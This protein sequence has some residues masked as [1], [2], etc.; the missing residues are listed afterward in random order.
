MAIEKH[1]ELF[2]S[3][4]IGEPYRRARRHSDMFGRTELEYRLEVPWAA[5]GRSVLALLELVLYRGFTCSLDAIVI[6][7]YSR[8]GQRRVL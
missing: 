5:V 4:L 8:N 3:T 7:F 1:N 6:P 2:N